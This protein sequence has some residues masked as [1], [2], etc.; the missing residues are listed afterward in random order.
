MNTSS[1]NKFRAW[2]K[3]KKAWILDFMITADGRVLEREVLVG[4]K[5]RVKIN[6]NAILCQSTGLLDKRKNL[7][8][9][10]D[11]GEFEVRNEFGSWEKI[12]AA[13]RWYPSK[14]SFSFE[15]SRPYRIENINELAGINIVSNELESPNFIKIHD[16]ITYGHTN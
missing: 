2:D 3:V 4:G 11:I 12:Y 6:L 10:R 15:I 1:K 9:D 14:G 16:P 13:M 5:K 7:I 8:F